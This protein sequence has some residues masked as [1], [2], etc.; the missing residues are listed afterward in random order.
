MLKKVTC[1]SKI[2]TF[3]WKIHRWTTFLQLFAAEL[4]WGFADGFLEQG[5][6]VGRVVDAAF[7]GDFKLIVYSLQ[8]TDNCPYLAGEAHQRASPEGSG[9]R[10]DGWEYCRIT[11]VTV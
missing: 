4:D 5:A 2:G 9:G 6:E 10:A 7:L 1:Y 8:E 11:N 3:L